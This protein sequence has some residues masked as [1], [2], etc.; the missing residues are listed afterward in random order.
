MT[1]TPSPLNDPKLEAATKKALAEN[2]GIDFA[3]QFDSNN[4]DAEDVLEEDIVDT[5]T[6]LNFD[7][8]IKGFNYTK[9]YLLDYD[10]F[11]KYIGLDGLAYESYKRGLWYYSHSIV[12]PTSVYK[13]NYKTNIDNRYHML[14]LAP[15]ASGKSTSK[16]KMKKLVD[17]NDCF[18]T[19][20][21]CHPQQLIGKTIP[22]TTR[23]PQR[24]IPGILTYKMVIHDE[25]QDFINEKNDLYSASQKLKRQAM[26][27]YGDNRIDK[28]LVDNEP[29]EHTTFYSP[30]CFLDFAHDVK[31]AS[32][33]FHTGSFRRYWMF[34]LITDTKVD[35]QSITEF[36]LDGEYDYDDYPKTLNAWYKNYKP[37]TTFDQNT[38]D[39]IA[40]CHAT[41]LKFLL[42][43]KNINA[44]RYGLIMRYNLR[45]VIS[46][47]V[48][49]LAISKKEK[50]PSIE[51]TIQGC[52][53]AILFILESIKAINERADL[54]ACTDLWK[55]LDEKN[56]MAL[57][58]LL[59]KKYTSLET[60]N[61]SIKKFWSILANIHGCKITQA[62]GHYYK[63]KKDG[64][65]DSKKG[66]DTSWL[67]LSYI[68]KE[69]K[70]INDSVCD[71]EFLDKLAKSV[72]SK[73]GVLTVLKQT[74]KK[75][76]DD[77]WEEEFEKSKSDGSVGVWGYLLTILRV[78]VP[79]FILFF[80]LYKGYPQI[81][82]QPTLLPESAKNSNKKASKGNQ[83]CQKH[84]KQ[85]DTLESE[86]Q[87]DKQ[88]LEESS[89]NIIT[90]QES[91][92]DTQYYETKKWD[93][94]TQILNKMEENK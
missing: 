41:L 24:T 88:Q 39:I 35:L 7:A 61:V 36:K 45:A 75:K 32:C 55:G 46:K 13:I 23:K 64:Y 84:Q 82:S 18:E 47:I 73:N 6:P 28:K 69:I 56:T 86:K 17:V 34:D 59:R 76:F 89:D 79:I 68:P 25:V 65:I 94:I 16:N 67:W 15:V 40:H 42:N 31:L 33:F 81:M 8:F 62:R 58:W 93:K 30:T 43:C 4:V 53:D 11:D 60:T 85:T 3:N 52:G 70:I 80:N 38:L 37:S 9:T 77:K 49:I 2:Y 48:Y 27:T 5:Q 90:T 50:I 10:N 87:P 54:G 12:Q 92:R 66:K 20:G 72:G 19:I 71:L 63:L 78:E 22:A 83:E 21:L 1:T 14:G 26:D 51:T 91:D 44:Y 74:F 57:T 29:G